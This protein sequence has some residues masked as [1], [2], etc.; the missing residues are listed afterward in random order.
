MDVDVIEVAPRDG[1]QN[2][3]T[4]LSTSAKV[5]LVNRSIES[6]ARRIEVTSFVNPKLVPQLADAD[7]VMAAVPR[8]VGVRYSALIVNERGLDRALAAAV[9]EINFIVVATEAFN[10]RNQGQSVEQ[11]LATCSVICEQARAAGIGTT[12]TIAAAFGCPFEGEVPVERVVDL[13][14]RVSSCGPDEICLADTIGVATP[15]DVRQR[16]A[17]MRD[18]GAAATAVRCHFHN[19]RNTGIA[20]AL[21]AI[22]SGATALDASVGGVGGCP[23]APAATGNIATEDLVYLCDRM[24]IETGLDLSVLSATAMWLGEQLGKVVPG[25]VSRAGAFPS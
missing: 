9:D 18:E 12:V 19:T 10:Q 7:D 8:M 6:G 24:G 20:N 1:L 25:L 15:G 23:F 5:D 21:A 11:S 2:E 14:K 4:S 17:A 13:A 22:E 3:P 16:L